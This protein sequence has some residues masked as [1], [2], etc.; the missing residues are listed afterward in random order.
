M[1]WVPSSMWFTYLQLDATAGALD[2]DLAVSNDA[3]VA[4]AKIDTGVSNPQRVGDGSTEMWPL[5][6]GAI[7]AGG[8]AFLV[9]GWIASGRRRSS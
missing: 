7:S 4:P 3:K 9:A 8:A 5:V 6:L 2:Y 1:E